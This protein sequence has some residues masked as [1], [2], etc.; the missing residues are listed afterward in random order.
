MDLEAMDLEAMD[1]GQWI[2]NSGL[3]TVDRSQGMGALNRGH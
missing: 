3:A 2:G 1:P